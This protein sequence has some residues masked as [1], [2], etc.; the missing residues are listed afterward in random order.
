MASAIDAFRFRDGDTFLL[1]HKHDLP[2]ERRDRGEERHRELTGW[3][4]RVEVFF[5]RDNL[6]AL[7]F[8]LLHDVEEVF[9][10]ARE[11]RELGDI[12][13]VAIAGEVDHLQ[14]S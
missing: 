5:E 2:F 10:A 4:C 14:E 1:A 11:T 13:R 6:H 12:N 8:E 3:R 7:V 9:R